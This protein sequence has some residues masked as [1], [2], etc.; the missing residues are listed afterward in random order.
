[1]QRQ[2]RSPLD[3]TTASNQEETY[4]AKKHGANS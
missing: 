1:M 3:I 4:L 2:Q